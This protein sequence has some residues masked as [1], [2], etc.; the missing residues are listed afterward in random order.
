VSKKVR[1]INDQ[2]DYED[3]KNNAILDNNVNNG[4]K[5]KIITKKTSKFGKGFKMLM[6]K[7]LANNRT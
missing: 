1:K 6:I 4:D 5:N 3:S 2:E 7:L